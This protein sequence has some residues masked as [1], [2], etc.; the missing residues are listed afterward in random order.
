MQGTLLLSNSSALLAQAE[1]QPSA[2][3]LLIPLLAVLAIFWLLLI[4]PQ[5]KYRKQ[6]QQ[7]L[8]ALRTGDKIV[9]AGG[10]RAT[11]VGLRDEVVQLRIADQVR[12]DV[13]RSAIARHQHQPE[14]QPKS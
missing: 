6:H 2:W 4:R 5:Q 13:D 1:Q 11:V 14:E 9:T 8:S 10:I 7:M 3:G 12:I